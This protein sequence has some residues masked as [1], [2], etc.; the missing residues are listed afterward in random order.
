MSLTFSRP[1]TAYRLDEA[2]IYKVAELNQHTARVLKEINRSGRPAAVTKHGRFVAMIAPLEDSK[3]ESAV[4]AVGPLTAMFRQRAAEVEQAEWDSD[5][6]LSDEEVEARSRSGD[7]S[8][9]LQATHPRAG[10][11]HD[12]NVYTVTEL[13]QDTARVLEEI[14]RSGQPAAVTRHGKLQVMIA[15]LEGGKIESLVLSRGPLTEAFLDAAA[16]VD[17]TE[18]GSDDLMSDDDVEA[19]AESHR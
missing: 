6:L 11:L 18:W 17:A 9:D 13:N 15:P 10:S 12:A 8:L 4:L 19:R 2:R 7:H 5:A 1:R 14:N 16:E 3:I